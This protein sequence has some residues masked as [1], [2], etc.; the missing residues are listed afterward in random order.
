MRHFHEKHGEEHQ[1]GLSC[2]WVKHALPGMGSAR[3][4][5]RPARDTHRM[6]ALAFPIA[7]AGAMAIFD[8]KQNSL[9]LS[10]GG[11]CTVWVVGTTD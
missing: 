10:Y 11:A 1:T 8:R 3:R 9:N 6:Q 7:R 5:A 2:T 4:G